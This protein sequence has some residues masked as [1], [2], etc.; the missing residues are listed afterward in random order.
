[1]EKIDFVIPWVDGADPVWRAEKNEYEKERVDVDGELDDANDETRYRDLGFLRYWFRGVEQFAPWVNKVYFVT[2]GQKPEW[3]NVQHPK[4][5]CVH[6]KEYIPEAYLPTF[7]ANTIELNFHRI[8]GL[9][10][11]FVYFND[12]MFLLK[13]VTPDYFYREGDPVLVSTLRYPGLVD[14]NNWSRLVFNDYCLVNRSHEIGRSIWKNRRKWFSVSELELHRVLRNL[15]CYIANKTL[16]VGNFG[17]VAQPHL[18]STFS[19]VWEK[20][21]AELNQSCL[22]KF[23]SDDQVN[24][25]LMCAWNQALGKFFPSTVGKRGCRLHIMP[26]TMEA[27]CKMIT[28]Q[29]VPQICINDGQNTRE[30]EFCADKIVSAFEQ[31]L[32]TKSS[33]ELF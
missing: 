27:I 17:H 12:D 33:F 24:Q 4:L 8:E 7:N 21:P 22:H 13:P 16:P 20:C 32:P 18:K 26:E 6:H 2:C 30:P 14:Y 23:R 3:L 1:M 29:E 15:V 31:I 10:E 19:S 25:W 9:S 28:G 5:V 11:H